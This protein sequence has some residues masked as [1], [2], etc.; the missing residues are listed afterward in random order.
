MKVLFT[1]VGRRTYMV[2]F[3]IALIG[4]SYPIELHVSDCTLISAAMHVS[5]KVKVHLLPPVLEDS[6]YYLHNLLALCKKEQFEIIFP[7]SDL[8]T[9]LLSKYRQ[10]FERIGCKVIV[11]DQITIERCNDK[12]LTHEICSTTGIPTPK[13]WFSS[14]DYDGTFPVIQ[15]HIF[16]SG[17]SGLKVVE[18]SSDLKNFISH[19]DMLQQLIIGDEFG[20]DILNDLNGNLVAVCAKRKLSMRSGETDKAEIIK[21]PELL[22]LGNKISKIFRHIGNLDCDV[23]RNEQGELFCIDFNPRFGGG[24]PA[25]H[26]AGFNYLKAILDMVQ[27][28]PYSLPNH[29]KAVTVMKG[30]SLYSYNSKVD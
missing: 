26:L 12:R 17:S 30:I 3:V 2:E 25:T 15:K 21:D 28:R 22:D 19:Q 6:E 1:N 29:P 5:S 7:L 20:L 18:R 4:E 27:M 16:G 13:T 9:L 8:D 24:Y 23:L 11:S 14:L 10:E